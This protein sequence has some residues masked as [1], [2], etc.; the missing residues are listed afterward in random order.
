MTAIVL[1]P[2][3]S[4][5]GKAR[6]SGD[7]LTDEELGQLTPATE[8]ALISGGLIEMAGRVAANPRAVAMDAAD[9]ANI[10]ALF[11]S[12]DTF[13]QTTEKSLKALHDKIDALGGKKPK[14]KARPRASAGKE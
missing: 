3:P 12:M 9:K 10:S 13:R 4:F 1:K 2:M 8:S 5:L 14:A 6:K 11:A 7:I